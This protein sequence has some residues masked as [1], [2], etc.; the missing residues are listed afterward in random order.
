MKPENKRSFSTSAI[1]INLV[2]IPATITPR[3]PLTYFDCIAVIIDFAQRVS[4]RMTAR[5]VAD[6]LSATPRIYAD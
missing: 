3:F 1:L 4:R 6:Y 5:A 2:T